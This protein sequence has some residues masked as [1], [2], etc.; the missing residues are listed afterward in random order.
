[1]LYTAIQCVFTV[2]FCKSSVGS[3]LIFLAL[4]MPGFAI[5]TIL[6]EITGLTDF[7]EMVLCAV[8]VSDFIVTVIITKRI[9]KNN[10]FVNERIEHYM[11]KTCTH[12]NA[13]ITDDAT[14]C[15]VCGMPVPVV[16]HQGTT[17]LSQDEETTVLNN[18]DDYQSGYKNTE[19]Y[20][21]NIDNKNN[22][23][24]AYGVAKN[25]GT[26]PNTSGNTYKN[27]QQSPNFGYNNQTTYNIQ[28]MNQSAAFGSVHP[29]HSFVESYRLFWQ[30]YVNFNG[31]FRRSDYWNVFLWNIIINGAVGLL[32]MIPVV[33]VAFSGLAGLFAIASFLPMIALS[34]RR[35]QD[36]G[37][38]GLLFLLNL[39]PIVGQIV[40]VVFYCQ[41]SDPGN[42]R[43]G[44]NPKYITNNVA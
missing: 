4:L 42:N 39:I 6:S 14:Y 28:N 34:V 40:L 16:A 37:K 7:F 18:N 29:Q 24:Y 3:M 25:Y 44:E 30:N 38:S 41:D 20:G 9:K 8:I 19:F 33:G 35:L 26:D 1:M 5:C 15:P 12:C 22:F 21:Q 31:R 36:T 23:Q 10:L 27:I 11:N 43:Y 32:S 2:C 17:V 13:S